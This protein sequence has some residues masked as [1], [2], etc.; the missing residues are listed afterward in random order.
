MVLTVRRLSPSS[1]RKLRLGHCSS[2]SIKLS[3]VDPEWIINS[4]ALYLVENNSQQQN[5]NAG[6]GYIL[7]CLTKKITLLNIGK[8]A[9]FK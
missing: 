9:N 6:I 5:I 4:L 7:V 8:L 1:K 2:A 3:M